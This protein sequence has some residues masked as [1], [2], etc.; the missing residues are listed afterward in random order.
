[1]NEFL[2]WKVTIDQSIREEIFIIIDKIALDQ[3]NGFRQKNLIQQ[4]ACGV[5]IGERK[6]KHFFIKKFTPPM[7]TDNRSRYCC[8][9]K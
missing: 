6:G 5:I 1:M 8:K 2:L 4:E 3:I 9:R 7:P